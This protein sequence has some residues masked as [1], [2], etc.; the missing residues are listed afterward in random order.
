[1][2]KHT[3]LLLVSTLLMLSLNACSLTKNEVTPTPES[4]PVV[5][6]NIPSQDVV[7]NAP[8]GFVPEKDLKQEA[9][10]K[11]TNIVK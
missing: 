2:K 10:E 5:V 3:H 11:D 6:E 4:M 9:L 1:M 8:E 7:Q